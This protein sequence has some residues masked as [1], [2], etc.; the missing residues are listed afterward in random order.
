MR[1]Q[2]VFG[3]RSYALRPDGRAGLV[4]L[5]RGA[6]Q[7][8]V[9]DLKGGTATQLSTRCSRA[10]PASTIPS[11]SGNG[12]AAQV[13]RPAAPPAVMRIARGSLQPVRRTAAGRDRAS[14]V[15]KG[16]VR[17]FRRPD[18][19]VVYGIYYAPRNAAAT[20]GPRKS[21]PPALVL[22][23]GGPTSMT[24]AGLKMRVQFY[25]SRGFAVLDV[26]YSGSTGYGR[27]YR[28]RLDGPGASPT[29]PTARRAR[30]IWPRP[31]WPTA[32]A[33]PSPAAAPAATPR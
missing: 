21:A 32:R 33:S 5:V 19:Q 8:E 7:F 23:H 4:S 13:A 31:A 20:A 24:D 25:T 15:S 28:Q 18:G 14:L 27:A 10:P 30:V 17:E 1:P 9:R 12:F 11:P 2:W 3:S 26:N 29:S 22:A 16:E 6:P